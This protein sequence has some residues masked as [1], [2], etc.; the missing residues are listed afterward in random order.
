M[1]DTK[2]YTL[3]N[4]LR[5]IW[6]GRNT[7][8]AHLGIMIDAGSRH[9]LEDE[10]GLAH[11]I[12]HTLFK[13]TK[14]RSSR[15]IINALENVGGELNAYT[16]KEETCIY[17]SLP[18]D[19]QKYAFSLLS[20]ILCNAQFPEDELVK[21]KEVVVDEILSYRDA[22]SER[23]FDDFEALYY[24]DQAIGRNVL[25]CEE[26]VRAFTQKGIFAFINR[27][28]HPEKMVI[29]YVGPAPFAN[30]LKRVEYY[31]SSIPFVGQGTPLQPIRSARFVQRNAESLAQAH[32]VF[33]CD[34]PSISQKERIAFSLLTNVLGGPG[35]NSILN[36]EMR[37]KCGYT[38]NNEASYTAFS[39]G[40]LLQIYLGT[41]LSN[42]EKSN[43]IVQREIQ[44]MIKQP[45]SPRRLKYAKAQFIGQHL[46]MNENGQNRMLAAAKALLCRNRLSSHQEWLDAVNGITA[47]DIQALAGQY[48]MPKDL[49]SLMLIPEE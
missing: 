28:F 31:F 30:I 21:E 7:K 39:D 34:A 15:Q 38:Y 4:G 18:A 41:D 29:S 16:S 32:A 14:N 37:E 47:Q 23:I 6:E 33:G 5:L 12:E 35:M 46:M 45:L 3:S 9:E 36:I 1:Q 22:P 24:P 40:G 44:K 8:V 27:N 48:L 49:S 43:T 13:G 25:G 19:Q 17:A 20:D 10:N 26:S 42:L 2:I 11:F